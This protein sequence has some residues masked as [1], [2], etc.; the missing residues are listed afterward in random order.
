MFGVFLA[1]TLMIW[2]LATKHLQATG[3][4][5]LYT[6]AL[7][8]FVVVCFVYLSLRNRLSTRILAELSR[9]QATD[10]VIL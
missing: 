6:A 7:V 5:Q 10:P 4:A 3:Y 2:L 1:L 8:V 9:I